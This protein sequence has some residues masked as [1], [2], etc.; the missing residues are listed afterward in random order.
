[1]IWKGADD[2]KKGLYGFLPHD[3]RLGT[4]NKQ[5]IVSALSGELKPIE[6]AIGISNKLLKE[7]DAKRRKIS[8]SSRNR[9]QIHW[10]TGMINYHK[11]VLD[12]LHRVH[13]E[14]RFNA[15]YGRVYILKKKKAK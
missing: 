14:M 5:A 15:N 13:D 9:Q 12:V 1:M 7:L 6:R 8:V 10:I 2:M 3:L 4:F 11:R